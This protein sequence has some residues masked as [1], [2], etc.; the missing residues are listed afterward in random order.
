MNPL[1]EQ[2]P[3]ALCGVA[4]GLL[5][6]THDRSGGPLPVMMCAG[7]GLV[8]NH[9]I[10]TAADLDHFYA[11]QYRKVYKKVSQPKLKHAARYFPGV[12][13]HV[14]AGYAHYRDVHSVLDVGCGSGE[15][16]Y[17]M[18]GLRK[19]VTGIEPNLGYAAFCRQQLG[20]PVVTASVDTFETATPVDH[21]RVNHVLEHLRNPLEVLI[22]LRRFLTPT[23]HIYVRV[24]NFE[25]GCQSKSPGGL[26]HYGHI[27]NFSRATLD[28]LVALAGYRVKTRIGP[29]ALFL[30]PDP[31]A[32][33][34]ALP[35][36]Q[37][38]QAAAAAYARH[39][40]GAPL[41]ART[42]GKLS[43]KLLRAMREQVV[44]LFAR[45]HRAIGDRT[46]VSLRRHLGL[47]A[48]R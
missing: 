24:P 45:D 7:C 3:C 8:H 21:I 31:S 6:E 48:A 42:P 20:L 11:T 26:F 28:R 43:R 34:A 23:G 38:I 46:L 15:F 35:S 19:H 32:R 14:T 16:L 25:Q 29:T 2:E 40:T 18:R 1:Q 17:L 9:P 30:E 5:I 33:P 12:A 39:R 27:F 13:S 41:S 47:C 36:S 4:Q 22:R 44:C 37:E 10:P